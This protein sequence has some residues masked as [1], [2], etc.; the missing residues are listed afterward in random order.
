MSS[1]KLPALLTRVD[2]EPS[3]TRRESA[4]SSPSQLPEVEHAARAHEPSMTVPPPP[5]R[6]ERVLQH[7]IAFGHSASRERHQSTPPPRSGLP[8]TRFNPGIPPLQ[9]LEQSGPSPALPSHV[10]APNLTTYIHHV[11]TS[12]DAFFYIL[13]QL[14]ESAGSKAL[15]VLFPCNTL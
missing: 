7:G 6:Q 2:E 11:R 10:N 1:G 4:L 5:A 14:R 12:Y 3:A 13:M 9:E 8:S 15:F